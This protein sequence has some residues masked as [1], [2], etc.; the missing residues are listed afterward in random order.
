MWYGISRGGDII[1]RS[2]LVDKIV[3]MGIIVIEGL[4]M[5][6]KMPKYNEEKATQVA[7]LLLQ[8]SNC[9]MDLLKFMKIMYN[10]E[11][12]ALGRWSF[13]VTYASICSMPEGQVLSETYDNTKPHNPRVFWDEY[14][15]TDRNRNTVSLKKS[16]PTG[17]L[18]RAEMSLIKEIYNRD[19]DKSPIELRNEHHD[20]PE[21]V[22]PGNSSIPTDYIEL[23][24]VLGKTPEQIS[25]FKNDMG[26]EA[27]LEE[28]VV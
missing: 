2:F 7:A 9:S 20:Y 27:Y 19:K 25:A 12:E 24:K 3:E 23:L 1:P 16:C 22:D 5:S 4:K 28:L 26:G 21:W 18:C 14:I 8:Q 17:Q 11:R 10:I 6:V 15:D 13:P